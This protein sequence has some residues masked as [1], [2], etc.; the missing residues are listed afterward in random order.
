MD[1]ASQHA[2]AIYELYNKKHAGEIVPDWWVQTQSGLSLA[3]YATGK[4]RLRTV[5]IPGNSSG[6]FYCADH[7]GWWL[8]ENPDE[9]RLMVKRIAKVT[10]RMLQR[11]MK[12]TAVP[13]QQSYPEV[14][15]IVV[16][17]LSRALEELDDLIDRAA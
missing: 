5:F 15:R 17:H 4:E 13:M 11:V 9:G 2:V 1:A 10:K 16:R 6:V 7:R 12:S 8:S 3:Q 14:A